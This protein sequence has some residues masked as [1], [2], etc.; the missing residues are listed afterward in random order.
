MARHLL[1][2][3]KSWAGHSVA[4]DA[5]VDGDKD[6]R[7]GRFIE[8]R[9]RDPSRGGAAR[10]RNLEADTLR[11]VLRAVG[12][13]SGVESNDLVAQDVAAGRQAR[14]DLDLPG[15]GRRGVDEV[16][17]RPGAWRAGVVDE[18]ARVDLEEVERCGAGRSAAAGALGHVVDHGTVVAVRPSVPHKRDGVSGVDRDLSATRLCALVAS[19]VRG[20]VGVRGD[21]T[22]VLV[23]REPSSS[24]NDL[25]RRQVVPVRVATRVGLATSNDASN[26]AVGGNSGNECEGRR[27]STELHAGFLREEHVVEFPS[28]LH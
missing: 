20:A 1:D 3:A 9:S 5:R 25:V 21:E 8:A 17:S 15:E 7:V 27:S 12:G 24:R 22:I 4:G 18:T 6:A 2:A 16:V 19:N 10:T 11:V 28:A 14:G 13:G 23:Q 26:V